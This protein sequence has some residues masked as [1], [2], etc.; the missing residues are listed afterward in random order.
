LKA[1]VIIATFVALALAPST[2]ARSFGLQAK[3]PT[4]LYQALLTTSYGKVPS[5]FYD[6]KVGVDDLSKLDKRHHAVGA[7]LVT[8]GGAADAAIYYTVFPTAADAKA[9]LAEPHGST[10]GDI[11]LVSYRTMG[12]VPG[13][14]RP[15]VWATMTIEGTN[16]FGKTVR[17]GVTAMGIA[18][19]NVVISTATIS[20][21]NEQSGDVPGALRLL[22]SA[23][24]HL[25]AIK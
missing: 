5:G 10:S 14:R 16:A 7:V 9:R 13:F 8:I 24:A 3:G 25:S 6:A 19:G 1:I 18:R 20:T 12:R 4:A 22:K 21:D 17:N 15:C 11:R 2:D 23:L